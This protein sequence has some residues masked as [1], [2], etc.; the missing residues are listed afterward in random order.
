MN[1][2]L[3][4]KNNLGEEQ[5]ID[6]KDDLKKMLI[7]AKTFVEDENYKVTIIPSLISIQPLTPKK[8]RQSKNYE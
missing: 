8:K 5:Q 1:F 6:F 4:I 2:L 7:V 3:V